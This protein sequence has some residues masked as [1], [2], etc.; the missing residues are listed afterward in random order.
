MDEL[1]PIPKFSGSPQ[2]IKDKNH[3]W[4]KACKCMIKFNQFGKDECYLVFEL[5]ENRVKL[6]YDR[7][8]NMSV[9][10][11]ELKDKWKAKQVNQG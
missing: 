10:G 5:I 3:E 6:Q 1:I 11:E 2:E 7:F 8:G 4:D 9:Y